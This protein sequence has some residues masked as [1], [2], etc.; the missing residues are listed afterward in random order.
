MHTCDNSPDCAAFSDEEWAPELLKAAN[1]AAPD[2]ATDWRARIALPPPPVSRRHA[3]CAYLRLL[4]QERPARDSQIRAQATA[5]WRDVQRVLGPLA[6]HPETEAVLVTLWCN[7]GAPLFYF[8]R[9]FARG[10]PAICCEDLNCMFPKGDDFYPAHPAYPSGH[11]MQA[12]ALAYFYAQ[13]FP[14]LTDRLMA[15]AADIARNR[16]VAG[17]HY[18]SDSQAG[19]L[20]ASQVVDMLFQSPSFCHAAKLAAAEWP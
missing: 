17:L 16:E 9:K 7:L 10:R 1:A 14:S 20:L 2:L 4:R 13:L 5:V 12:H 6:S 19:K 8:K 11:S 18:P 15:A 3:E